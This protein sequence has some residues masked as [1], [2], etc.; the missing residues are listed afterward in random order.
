MKTLLDEQA[1]SL[2][3]VLAQADAVSA[4]E[5]QAKKTELEAL[6]KLR[7]L[8]TTEQWKDL[9]AQH[10]TGRGGPRCDGAGDGRT[11]A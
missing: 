9:R 11:P 8:L 7:Q 1:P 6:V 10:G 4:L 3:A 2:E 5:T